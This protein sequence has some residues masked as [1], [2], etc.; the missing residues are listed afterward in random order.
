MP[1]RVA[2]PTRHTD[3]FAS[4]GFVHAGVLLGLTELAY[5]AFE[6]HAGVS[7]PEYVVAVQR[8]THATYI[9]PLPWQNGVEILVETLD[10]SARGFEQ[11]CTVRDATTTERVAVFVH[12]YAWL[13]TRTGKSEPLSEET[14][15]RF[16][17]G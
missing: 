2:F 15:Q 12:R 11:R 17:A 10:A 8:E 4:T 1:F 13:N 6:Q 5:G 9:R 3:A 7:K 14:Q 16:L